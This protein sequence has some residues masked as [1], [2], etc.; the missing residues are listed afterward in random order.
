MILHVNILIFQYIWKDFQWLP[1]IF[2][3]CFS[4]Q[5]P[6]KLLKYMDLLIFFVLY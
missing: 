2:L 1:I 4:L 5:M 6:K 3:G